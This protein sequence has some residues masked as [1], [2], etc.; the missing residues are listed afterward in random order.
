LPRLNSVSCEKQL[1]IDSGE[2]CIVK[3][4]AVVEESSGKT[5]DDYDGKP[6]TY[7]GLLQAEKLLSGLMSSQ[8]SVRKRLIW[9]L[10]YCTKK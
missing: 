8:A 6:Q 9:L 7:G 3:K 4:G 1:W 5:V 10:G 2:G